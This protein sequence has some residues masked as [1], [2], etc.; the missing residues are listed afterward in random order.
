[1]LVCPW[2]DQGAAAIYQGEV[3]TADALTDIRP[4]D[5]LGA[6][7]TFVAGFLANAVRRG[8]TGDRNTGVIKESLR[9]G[10]ELAGRKCEMYG[11]R[12]LRDFRFMQTGD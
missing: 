7:D 2:G 9:R 12:G 6:G 4:V 8:F 3:L 1:M 5:T 11:Y 10:C